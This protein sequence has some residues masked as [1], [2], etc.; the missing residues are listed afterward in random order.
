MTNNFYLSRFF[1]FEEYA[2]FV[3]NLQQRDK[4]YTLKEYFDCDLINSSFTWEDT[5]QGQNFWNDLHEKLNNE[6][7]DEFQKNVLKLM[8]I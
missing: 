4:L 3:E 7:D 5:P 2:F 8:I 1:N 6:N